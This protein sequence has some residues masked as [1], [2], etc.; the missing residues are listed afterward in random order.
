MKPCHELECHNLADI[1]AQ[2]LD[3]ITTRTDLLQNTDTGF[4]N[5]INTVDFLKRSPA[6]LRY[7]ASLKLSVKET[8]LLVLH[9]SEPLK[10]HI[11]EPPSVCKI[12]IPILNTQDTYTCWYRIPEHMIQ[13]APSFVNP[14]G[15]TLP[16]YGQLDLSKLELLAEVEVVRPVVFNSQIPHMVRVG[17]DAKL[18]RIMLACMLFQEPIHYL[19]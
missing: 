14:F 12:N 19:Q 6:L 7:F 10:L 13:E 5:K 3:Y 8:A 17:A 18:P 4:W 2:T 16:D 15:V 11:D 1:Q 9:H